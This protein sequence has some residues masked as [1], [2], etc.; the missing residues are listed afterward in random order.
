MYLSLRG[1]LNTGGGK[2]ENFKFTS[3]NLS[4][5]ILEN[6]IFSLEG[7]VASFSI[8]LPIIYKI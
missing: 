7:G 6:F 4:K 8:C 2:R 3:Q 5:E 1:Y